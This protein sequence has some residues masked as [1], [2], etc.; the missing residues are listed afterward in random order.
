MGGAAYE[1]MA[2]ALPTAD[3]PLTDIMN[4]ARKVVFSRTLRTGEWA[5]TTFAA[6]D[7]TEDLIL[8]ASFLS[9]PTNEMPKRTTQLGGESAPQPP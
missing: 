3:H 4:A 9:W 1:A 2:G 8:R 7:T 6:G 5:N